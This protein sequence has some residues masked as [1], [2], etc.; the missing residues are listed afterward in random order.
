M[1]ISIFGLGYVGAVS[2]GCLARD[3][4]DVVGCDID[5][6]KLDLLA[7]GK[8]PIIEEGMEDLIANAAKGGH[9]SVTND[10]EEAVQKSDVSLICVGTPSTRTGGQDLTAVKRLAEQLGRALAKKGSYHA[11]VMRST[12]LPGTVENVVGPLLEEHSGLKLGQDFGLCFQP[13][14]L[15]EG[16]S[17]KDYDNPPFT[18]VGT[19]DER[20]AEMLRELFGH[21]PC[22]F[23]T[24][25]ITSAEMLKMC[26]NTF[27]ALKITFAN[28]V[29]RISQALGVDSHE[30]MRLVCE[31]R[32]LNISPAYM[33]PGF[34]FGGSCLPKD[35]KALMAL[36]KTND[37]EVPMLKGIMP[38]NQ[39]H[40]DHAIDW[41]LHSGKR[42]VGMIGLSFKSG[43]DDL[44]ESPLVTM[45]ERFIGKGL[46]LEIFD[47]EVNV[48]RLMGAN[49][50]YIEESIPHISQLMRTDAKSV[51]D[52]ADVVVVG[53]RDKP[54]MAT[55]HESARDDQ[56]ILDL[57]NV[58]DRDK[59]A[60]TYRGVC[61]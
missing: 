49:R 58:P 25:T 8:T 26:C 33:K 32:Q 1:R 56:L 34:A 22:E 23:V 9:L 4:H 27:H 42:K 20:P 54:L 29:G 3:G 44:R 19:N 18:V 50:R 51:I 55:L 41:V 13:E 7:S 24:T 43:T 35:V 21:L 53:L 45:A 14:F 52:A 5:Q 6:T 11:F 12:V 30:V 60:G 61:W 2:A 10:A 28:E 48:A 46:N 47:P 38:S 16:S 31:D 17:I 15:R 37:V 39:I 40:I 59:L 57:V 36:A